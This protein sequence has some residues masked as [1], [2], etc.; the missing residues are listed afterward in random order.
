M[1]KHTTEDGEVRQ[2]ASGIAFTDGRNKN[3]LQ[4]SAIHQGR[5]KAMPALSVETKETLESV[6]RAVR[7]VI[8]DL[9]LGFKLLNDIDALVRK[10]AEGRTS[11][12]PY[13]VHYRRTV[14]EYLHDGGFDPAEIGNRLR[15]PIKD[16]YHDISALRKR[17]HKIKPQLI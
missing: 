9:V 8:P 12:H 11:F 3:P 17:R 1:H 2:Y 7:L 10:D 4:R 6:E 16:V 5:V 13:V 14:V 15:I